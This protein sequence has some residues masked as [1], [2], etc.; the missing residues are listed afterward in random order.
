MRRVGGI[1]GASEHLN[2]VLEVGSVGLDEGGRIGIGVRSGEGLG[3]ERRRGNL[4][5]IVGVG[6][7]HIAFWRINGRWVLLSIS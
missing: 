1:G 5:T 7:G 2:D 6:G 3:G 4:G